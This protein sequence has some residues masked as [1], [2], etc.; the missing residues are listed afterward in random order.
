MKSIW[1]PLM[2]P[3]ALISLTASFA[4]LA[5]GRSSA[6]SSPV[7]AKPPPILMVPPVLPVPALAPVLGAAAL[8][9][10]LGAAALAPV[11]GAAALEPGA[12]VAA[13]ELHA[14]ARPRTVASANPRAMVLRIVVSSGPSR[15]VP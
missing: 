11:L 7:R 3:A 9:P 6:D 8:A 15:T 12:V 1:L 14:A 2:P 4:P 10:V 13:G 5:A